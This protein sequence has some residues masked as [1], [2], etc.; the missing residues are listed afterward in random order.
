MSVNPLATAA[1]SYHEQR[2]G[3]GRAPALKDGETRGMA[4]LTALQAGQ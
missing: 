2:R 4:W 1:L 3:H